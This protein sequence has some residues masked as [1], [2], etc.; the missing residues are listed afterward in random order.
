MIYHLMLWLSDYFSYLNVFRYI[1]FRAIYAALTAL[2]ICLIFGP[3]MIRKLKELQVG[4]P[5]RDDGPK[6]HIKKAGTPT[7]GGVLIVG[8]MTLS[9]LLWAD[10]VNF[11]IVLVLIVT[12]SYAAIGFIDD[13]RKQV[14]KDSKGLPG[15]YKFFWQIMVGIVVGVMLYVAPYYLSY[16]NYSTELSVPFL[17]NLRPDLGWFYI[18]FAIFIIVGASNAVNLT[19]GLDG[20]AAGP[21]VAV[22]LTYLVFA[23][24]T[25]NVK[26]ADYLLITYLPGTGE[27][28]V[29]CGAMIGATMGFLWYN[30]Y[31]AEIF[32]GD[33]GALSLG[34]GIGTVAVLT[35]NELLLVI[36]GGLFVLETLSV[37]FQV[38][39][40]K[41]K[42][43][44]IFKMAP[45]HHH[46]ELLGWPEPKIIVRFWIISIILALLALSTLKI[47]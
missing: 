24:C 12:L 10:V 36:V 22:A 30:S 25:G 27:L 39:F 37:I 35:K 8:A 9:T 19:D 38:G 14:K 34:G 26:I 16:I 18:P 21:V 28:A 5:I 17:K 11:Y 31:P 7:M 45:L 3:Y 46:F 20:L 47:R 32:M 23:Y 6:T 2:I 33:V 41:W 1:T 43:R 42:K 40:F 29:F 44:R 4:Q 13:W 15:R